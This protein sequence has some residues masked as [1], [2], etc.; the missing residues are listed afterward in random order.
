MIQ[1]QHKICLKQRFD[2]DDFD[3]RHHFRQSLHAHLG[4]VRDIVTPFQLNVNNID[5][6]NDDNSD[7]ELENSYEIQTNNRTINT[8]A[9]QVDTIV[10]HNNLNSHDVNRIKVGR[11]HTGYLSV[12]DIMKIQS[13]VASKYD[14]CPSEIKMFIS[15]LS[16]KLKDIASKGGEDKDEFETNDDSNDSL[17]KQMSDIIHNYKN[18]FAGKHNSFI[19]SN[20]T[21]VSAG[22]KCSNS[23]LRSQS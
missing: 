18:S 5:S 4:N 1:C 19:G 20:D 8:A 14:S 13:E 11:C 21:N 6:Y 22:N 10:T 15:G 3:V 16:I 12:R 9:Q 2:I 17:N 23:M 7:S